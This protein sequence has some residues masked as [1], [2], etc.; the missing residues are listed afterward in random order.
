MKATRPIT[1]LVVD[2]C[3][4]LRE[5]VA[6]IFACHAGL[7]VVAQGASG[8]E[9]LA[10]WRRTHPDVTLLDLALPDTNGIDVIDALRSEDP[11]ARIIV[12]TNYGGVDDV[13][14]AMR[15]GARGYILKNATG[16]QIIEA[17]QTVQG[18][19]RYLPAALEARLAENLP[20]GELT[21]REL[22]VLECLCQGK[23]DRE[24]AAALD[25]SFS[26]VR[27]HVNKILAKLGVQSRSQAIV[28]ALSRGTIH[29]NAG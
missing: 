8:R 10:L 24:I 9:A 5:G 25:I 4:V 20:G 18:G 16:R 17:V 27:T 14:R 28:T 29:R 3:P 22:E 15:A 26:T 2:V 19:G 12:F 6:T 11:A 23:Q 21:E 13:V 1:V 7:A